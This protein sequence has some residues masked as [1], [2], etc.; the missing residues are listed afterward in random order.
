MSIV[1]GSSA[2]PEDGATHRL[3]RLLAELPDRQG[4]GDATL[5]R[6]SEGSIDLG[7]GNPDT[8]LLP[9]AL[10]R[11][12]AHA[13]T[14]DDSFDTLLRYSPSAGLGSFRGAIAAREQVSSDR[15]IVTNGGAH[16]LAL[17]VLAVLDPGDTIVVDDPVYPLFLRVLE[18]VGVN[19]VALPV[20]PDGID[21]D[22]LAGRLRSG[23]RP[24]ALFT[25]PTFQNPSGGTL[26]AEKSAALVDLAERYGFTI[27][28]DD[29]YREIAFPGT[30][31]PDRPRLR[32]T[33]RVV[34]VN[35]FSKTLGPGLRL[36]WLTVPG[37]L[38]AGFTKL[39]NRLDGQTSGVLQAIVERMLAD[40]RYPGAISAAAEGY[41]RKARSLTT[42]LRVQFDGRV[43]LTEPSGGFFVWARPAGDFDPERLFETAQDLGVTFQRG[44]W[45]AAGAEAFRG[46]LRLSFSEP[47]DERLQAGVERLAHAWRSV[48]D[49]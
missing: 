23:L 28:A 1:T 18:L 49:S 42:A 34:A 38:S 39:R 9:T 47:S 32:D 24:K 6:L 8:A 35:S 46:Y 4:F 40:E 31:V 48:L 44:E 33:D 3:S 27:I 17:S 2:A 29:P 20:G 14:D 26:S 37:A 22:A 16:G 45:F 25:V 5:I 13:V 21:V 19:V 36:G 10:Y 41:Q 7:G 11:D 15:I 30:V 12:A 43:E